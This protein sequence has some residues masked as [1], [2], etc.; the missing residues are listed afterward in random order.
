MSFN[1]ELPWS[2]CKPGDPT[3]FKRLNLSS[4]CIDKIESNAFGGLS[5]LVELN[6]LK[7]KICRLEFDLLKSLGS[8]KKLYYA[9]QE[10]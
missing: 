9:K 10:A 1:T 6:L 5:K 3:C 4:N 7:N 8:L 2:N